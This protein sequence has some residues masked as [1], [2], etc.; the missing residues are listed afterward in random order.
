MRKRSISISGHR[1]SVL[2]EPEF[3]AVLDNIAAARSTSLSILIAEIDR[4]RL[5]RAP[6][7]GLA[8]AL[9]VFALEEARRRSASGVGD[10]AQ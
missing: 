4:S 3:W 1:T 6:A 2:L 9:R 5:K 7:P 10:E 8:S